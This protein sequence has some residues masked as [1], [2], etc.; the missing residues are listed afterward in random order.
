M[1]VRVLFSRRR[2]P[3]SLAIRMGTWSAWSHV[4]LV[5][6]RG[7]VPELI[8]AVAPV[9]VVRLPMAER[10]RLVVC[11]GTGGQVVKSYCSHFA[12]QTPSD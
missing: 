4:D 9:G 10:L 5:D 11:P 3:G 2:H 7:A 8:G 12:A 6:D 1:A